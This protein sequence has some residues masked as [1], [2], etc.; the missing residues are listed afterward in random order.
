MV[1]SSCC[2]SNRKTRVGGC[3]N[4]AYAVHVLVRKKGKKQT[5]V[6]TKGFE[7]V[8]SRVRHKSKAVIQQ[9]CSVCYVSPKI[10]CLSFF[11]Q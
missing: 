2:S 8:F 7:E 9:Q 11:C 6:V 1:F 3:E 5:N 4:E 10:L